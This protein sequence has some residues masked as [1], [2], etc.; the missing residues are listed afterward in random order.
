MFSL[1]LMFSVWV[2][3]CWLS[4]CGKQSKDRFR[5]HSVIFI[6][7]DF[8][9]YVYFVQTFSCWPEIHVNILRN[10]VAYIQP[11]LTNTYS[12][13]VECVTDW[14][15]HT[16]SRLGNR[17]SSTRWTAN[18]TSCEKKRELLKANIDDDLAFKLML[19]H[20]LLTLRKTLNKY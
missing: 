13:G 3:V 5:V 17:I 20:N 8:S 14:A 7:N 9:C 18:C 1:L 4:H 6:L 11:V 10:I 2:L 16:S 15:Y 12:I 19:L